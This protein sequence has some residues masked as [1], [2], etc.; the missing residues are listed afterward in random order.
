VAGLTALCLSTL[1]LGTELPMYLAAYSPWTGPFLIILATAL[2]PAATH[3]ILWV[4]MP[5]I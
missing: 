4:R 5:L 2:W 1:A 3:D